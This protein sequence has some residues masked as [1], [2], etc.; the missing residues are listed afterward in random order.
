MTTRALGPMFIAVQ[1][2]RIVMPGAA[3]EHVTLLR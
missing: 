1:R 3:K 2:D